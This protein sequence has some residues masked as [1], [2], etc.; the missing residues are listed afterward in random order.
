MENMLIEDIQLF[1]EN[2][3][4]SKEVAKLEQTIDHISKIQNKIEFAKEENEKRISEVIVKPILNE[5]E[6]LRNDFVKELKNMQTIY[7][8]QQKEENTFL[9]QS[10]RQT[11]ELNENTIK[12]VIE[13]LKEQ[14]NLK[15]EQIKQLKEISITHIKNVNTELAENKKEL[16]ETL[17]TFN[18]LEEKIEQK[19]KTDKMF[20]IGITLS[21]AVLMVV[22]KFV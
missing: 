2:E 9:T 16:T 3:D 17:K 14:N 6:S 8:K 19:I 12:S 1:K 4:I 7:F 5:V 11:I 15:N 13:V 22:L 18:S 20:F 21:F 10:I